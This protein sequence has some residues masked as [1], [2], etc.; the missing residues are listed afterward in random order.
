MPQ[1]LYQCE[2]GH[3]YDSGFLA[4]CPKCGVRALTKTTG[5][6]GSTPPSVATEG[7]TPTGRVPTDM[8]G[9]VIECP[10]CSTKNRVPAVATGRFHCASCKK[11]LPQTADPRPQEAPPAPPTPPQ[12]N[13]EWSVQDRERSE[14]VD[15]SRRQVWA[16]IATALYVRVGLM[17]VFTF[18]TVS[19]FLTIAGQ[20]EQK[21][22]EA[23]DTRLTSCSTQGGGFWYFLAF[24]FALVGL[25]L[26]W[27]W[28]GRANASLREAQAKR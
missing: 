17:L 14:L 12:P 20:W 26:I 11:E 25:I 8:S 6:H 22:L 28:L 23:C 24:A 19:F 7:T 16:Q 9:R 10:A 27:V 21:R 4:K 15:S 1:N 2:C 3:A 18:M 5:S 13:P